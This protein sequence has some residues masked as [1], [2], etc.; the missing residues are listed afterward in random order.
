VYVVYTLASSDE[1]SG[2]G[3]DRLMFSTD[4]GRGLPAPSSG[5]TVFRF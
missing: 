5:P 3:S 1:K 2:N 4:L